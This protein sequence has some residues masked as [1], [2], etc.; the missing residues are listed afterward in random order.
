MAASYRKEYQTM[1]CYGVFNFKRICFSF[2]GVLFM[3]FIP[4]STSVFAT[5]LETEATNTVGVTYR[6][7]IQ[8]DGWAQGWMYNGAL[9]GSEG[10]SLRLE[11]IEIKLSG[12]APEGLGIEY[13]THVQNIG[14][15]QKW[16][17]NG[18]FSGSE[19]KSLRLEGIQIR[20]TGTNA[21]EYTVKYRTH[22]QNE[23]WKQGWVSDGV[24]S[25][26]EGKSLRLEA[27]EIVIE[28]IPTK[29]ASQTPT[30]TANNYGLIANDMS[31]KDSNATLLNQALNQYGSIT[32]D[33]TFY[34]G[35]TSEKV[36]NSNIQITG[37]NATELIFNNGK[38][39]VLFDPQKIKSL[40]ISNVKFTNQS[41][42]Y[43][44]L[45]V[46]DVYEKSTTKV[47]R[48]KVDG[49]T[50]QGDISLYR[51][52][53]DKS[54]NPATVDFGIGEFI[55]TN[56]NVSNTGYTFIILNDIPFNTVEISNNTIKNFQNVLAYLGL[57]NGI[58]Y[59]S[60]LVTARKYVHIYKNTVTC[61]D[62]WW[63]KSGNTYYAFVLTENSEVVYDS[64]YVEGLKADYDVALY[65]AYLS[66]TT[67]TYTN[68]TWKNNI[69]FSDN[70]TNN[71]LLKAKEGGVG[72]GAGTTPL[73]RMYS[74]N[75]FIVEEAYADRMGKPKSQLW[76]S[77]MDLVTYAE[78]YKIENNQINV[79]D[80]R[81]PES[82]RQIKNF[83][84]NNNVINAK[85]AL[86]ILAI[87]KLTDT[88]QPTIAMN[89]NNI[90]I[91]QT[92]AH[93]S[94]I[95]TEMQLVQIVDVRTN[96]ANPLA[97]SITVMGNTIK[98]PLIHVFFTPLCDTL[99]L[100]NNQFSV[101]SSLYRSFVYG[102]NHPEIATTTITKY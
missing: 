85:Y 98:A 7:H 91:A 69:V 48:V 96:T 22:I 5:N 25:G 41:T 99:T 70:K 74:N 72:G 23:G 12:T 76:V 65:D 8:N 24:L 88:C 9:S 84:F 92:G 52:Q 102:G 43:P 34:I 82:S 19:G 14:W 86:G 64:N 16:V 53:G 89:N 10:K 27:I 40:T 62:N 45:I 60:Q 44:L 75:T 35:N 59:E 83:T 47:D 51:Q 81:F 21:G 78:D 58:T 73:K 4:L 42:G 20:L 11:G 29:T 6:T 97:K 38:Q 68:N 32:L 26:S 80:L 37:V 13:R 31:K 87:I 3:L 93:P 49:C 66:S 71:T 28:K 56:N 33:G 39:T 63:A 77:F 1:N 36:T 15:E 61:D 79:Y 18:E 67:V 101:A 50:F 100:Q 57:T 2:I 17:S 30:L 95:T 54:L 94:G 55:F 46:Y 90:N